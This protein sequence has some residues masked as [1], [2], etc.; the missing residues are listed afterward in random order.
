MEQMGKWINS[1]KRKRRQTLSYSKQPLTVQGIGV[2]RII[3]IHCINFNQKVTRW[4][5][6]GKKKKKHYQ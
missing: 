5:S 6:H 1:K 3:F 2:Q 4:V